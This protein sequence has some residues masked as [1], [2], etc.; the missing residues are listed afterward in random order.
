MWSASE[1]KDTELPAL[2]SV[3]YGTFQ[4]TDVQLATNKQKDAENV[5]ESYIDFGFGNSR[6]K[7]AGVHR[8][9]VVRPKQDED[10]VEIRFQGMTCNPT[11]NRH[12]FPGWMF[13]FHTVYADLLF[14]EGVARVTGFS[15]GA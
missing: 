9:A 4:V 6:G 15:Y 2:N 5:L 3:I 1:L 14:R 11:E 7:F 8:F 12:I 10:S 13:S